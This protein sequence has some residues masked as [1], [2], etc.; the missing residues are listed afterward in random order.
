[1]AI[2][3]KSIIEEPASTFEY[4]VTQIPLTYNIHQSPL[5]TQSMFIVPCEAY[6]L[7][8]TND[9]YQLTHLPPPS[10]PNQCESCT[11]RF[12]TR[13]QHAKMRKTANMISH[14]PA[15]VWEKED[16][17]V[18]HRYLKRNPQLSING[19]WTQYK[20]IKVISNTHGQY[21]FP[22]TRE[23]LNKYDKYWQEQSRNT[24]WIE[25]QVG[26]TLMFEAMIPNNYNSNN[27]KYRPTTQRFR[28]RSIP[29]DLANDKLFLPYISY[30]SYN[31]SLTQFCTQREYDV[32]HVDDPCP[33]PAIMY[34]KE[35]NNSI[36]ELDRRLHT[37]KNNNQPVAHGWNKESRIIFI[38]IQTP[39]EEEDEDMY[40]SNSEQAENSVS[41]A[42]RYHE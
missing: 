18:E 29:Y 34:Q 20:Q 7:T 35:V 8:H 3:V 33:L 17:L 38:A 31:D 24:A 32:A 21:F 27:Q 39:D 12:N 37:F 19:T 2:N 10:D 28:S 4:D 30:Q 15:Y 13:Q 26:K 25:Y 42:D 22:Q 1:M 14:L 11:M 9:Q 16:T 6:D 41:M 40:L 5:P 23:P 36:K